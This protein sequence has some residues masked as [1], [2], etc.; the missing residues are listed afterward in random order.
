MEKVTMLT[1]QE[2]INHGFYEVCIFS[3]SESRFVYVDVDPSTVWDCY[4]SYRQL[5]AT[6]VHFPTFWDFLVMVTR[7]TY[8]SNK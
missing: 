4:K 7:H 3:E 1:K 5:G 6:R 8:D 2:I